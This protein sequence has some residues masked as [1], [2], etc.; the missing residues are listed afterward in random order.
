MTCLIYAFDGGNHRYCY[1]CQGRLCSCLLEMWAFTLLSISNNITAPCKKNNWKKWTEEQKYR[2]KKKEG[3]GGA[4]LTV[5][6]SFSFPTGWLPSPIKCKSINWHLM[7]FADGSAAMRIWRTDVSTWICYLSNNQTESWC[8][9][10]TDV[11]KGIKFL[12][13]L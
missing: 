1:F 3:W 12:H 11:A 4:T 7:C 13:P 2:A 9:S 5:L 10:F 6:W 8:W